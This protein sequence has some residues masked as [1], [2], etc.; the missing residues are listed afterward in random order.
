MQ[1]GVYY[2]VCGRTFYQAGFYKHNF[3]YNRNYSNNYKHTCSTYM[4]SASAAVKDFCYTN[5]YVKEQPLLHTC[6][7]RVSQLSFVFE[8][9]LRL[10][11]VTTHPS[12]NPCVDIATDLISDCL[13][14]R[15]M[16]TV[17]EMG[18]R[19]LKPH[20]LLLERPEKWINGYR[21]CR[22]AVHNWLL[23]WI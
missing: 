2:R 15:G 12:S 11:S 1:C 16:W 9:G 13:R 18:P 21:H 4:T 22:Q 19:P 5:M 17:L 7:E 3:C 23:S 8:P 14:K 20:R 10:S 6:R